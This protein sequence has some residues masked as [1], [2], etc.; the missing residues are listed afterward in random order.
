[1]GS[2]AVACPTMQAAGVT[3]LSDNQQA[4]A[5]A[6]GGA[7]RMRGLIAPRRARARC[8]RSRGAPT[9][10]R[11]PSQPVAGAAH[12]ACQP[13]GA[14]VCGERRGI[15][16]QNGAAEWSR[17][18]PRR[19]AR[20]G[21]RSAP[22]PGRCRFRRRWAASAGRA[23]GPRALTS[24]N[25]IP[26]PTSG[27]RP[28]TPPSAGGRRWAAGAKH[29]RAAGANVEGITRDAFRPEQPA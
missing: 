26:V 20:T 16:F 9:H 17:A 28:H 27:P 2:R 3:E 13:P 6:G 19:R 18:G 1:M 23:C 4:C 11:S 5:C 14:S 21:P 25:P 7:V 22:C 24:F 29:A 8:M 15:A 10:A 12:S